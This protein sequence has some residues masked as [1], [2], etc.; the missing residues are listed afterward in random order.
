MLT[1]KDLQNAFYRYFYRKYDLIA[2]NISIYNEFNEIDILAV[3]KSGCVDEIEIK[4]AVK[5]FR[6]DFEKVTK[7]NGVEMLKHQAL[8]KGLLCSNNFSFLIPEDLVTKCEIPDCFGLYVY[9]IGEEG[10]GRIRREQSPRLLHDRTLGCELKYE[11]AKKMTAK[12]W[13]YKNLFNK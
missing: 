8:K 6:N 13:H 12:F 2:N 7:I 9:Y 10:R 5:N 11:I 4:L 1:E 3:H